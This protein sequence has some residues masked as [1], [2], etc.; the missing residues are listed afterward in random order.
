MTVVM[1][2]FATTTLSVLID[3][4]YSRKSICS[5]QANI[6]AQIFVKTCCVILCN[7]RA[8]NN[9]WSNIGYVIMG[10]AFIV[11]VAIRLWS[12]LRNCVEILYGLSNYI[13][14]QCTRSVPVRTRMIALVRITGWE[15]TTHAFVYSCVYKN[16]CAFN[17]FFSC[18]Q[19]EYHNSMASTLQWV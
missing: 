13:G 19:K 16:M 1:R 15:G 8:F 4:V 18:S 10:L 7:C 9:V 12:Y 2:T 5:S 3:L 11:I 6:H 14:E 17:F